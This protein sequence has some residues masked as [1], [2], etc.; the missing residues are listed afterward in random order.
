[1]EMNE[2]RYFLALCDE[3]HFTRAAA[4]CGVSQP[5]LTTAI[6]KLE[7][8]LGGPLFDRKRGA[9]LTELGLTVQPFL[10]RIAWNADTARW[11]AHGLANAATPARATMNGAATPMAHGTAKDPG[12]DTVS[13]QAIGQ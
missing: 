6:K 12:H 11:R 8:E 13:P 3:K 10:Q 7:Q 5:S 1:M 2:I 9:E 4:R